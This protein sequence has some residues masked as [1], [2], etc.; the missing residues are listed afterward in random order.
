MKAINPKLYLRDAA[1]R[2]SPIDGVLAWLDELT[3]TVG[4]GIKTEWVDEGV[5]VIVQL[6]PRRDCS[7]VVEPIP[8]E[9]MAGQLQSYLRMYV[10]ETVES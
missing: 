5:I 6:N 4:L 3:A 1:D 2:P 7:V 9:T 10:D 8:S